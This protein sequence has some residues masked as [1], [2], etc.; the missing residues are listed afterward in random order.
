M[1]AF[2]LVSSV[3]VIQC[4]VYAAILGGGGDPKYCEWVQLSLKI[5]LTQ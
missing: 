1:K 4:G 5:A 3:G 2:P